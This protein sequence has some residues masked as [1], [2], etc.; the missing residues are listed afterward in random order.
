MSFTI[1]ECMDVTDLTSHSTEKDASN[2]QKT[3]KA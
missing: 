3:K 1:I 2:S